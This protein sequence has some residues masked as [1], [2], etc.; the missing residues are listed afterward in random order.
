MIRRSLSIALN[1]ALLVTLGAINVYGQ[2]ATPY[3]NPN[4][5]YQNSDESAWLGMNDGA[6]GGCTLF[7]T[8]GAYAALPANAG[9]ASTPGMVRVANQETVLEIVTTGAASAATLDCDLLPDDV[10]YTVGKGIQIT[11]LQVYYGVQTSALT[12][13]T[14]PQPITLLTFPTT[15][16]GTAAGTNSIPQ[17][18]GSNITAT[19]NPVLG[20]AQLSTTT[21]GLCYRQSITFSSP[22]IINNPYQRLIFEEVFNQTA[23]SAATY[24]LCGVQVQYSHVVF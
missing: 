20:S 11:G 22:I 15:P 9:G 12:S 4:S 2:G 23:A 6:G 5:Q 18:G 1:V 16:G 13:V 24:Q 19:F 21:T 3:V 7:L 17:S 8:T 10:R 14:A